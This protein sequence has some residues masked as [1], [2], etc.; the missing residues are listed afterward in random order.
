MSD[1]WMPLR[2]GFSTFYPYLTYE[3]SWTS[4]LRYGLQLYGQT[5]LTSSDVL[6]KDFEGLQ[7]AQNNILRTLE[8]VRIKDRK[9]FQI[10]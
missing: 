8:C 9:A 1:E 2:A 3:G 5:R 4:K 7:K 10:C 6:T